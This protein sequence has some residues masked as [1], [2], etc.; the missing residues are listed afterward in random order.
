MNRKINLLL[1]CLLVVGALAAQK[2]EVLSMDNGWRFHKG[3][4]PFPTIKGHSASYSNAKAGKSW[5]AAAPN[6]D[7]SDWRVLNLP[8]DWAVE[9]GFNPEANLSQGYRDRGY[10]WYRRKFEVSSADKGKHFEL[11]LDGIATYATIW[12]NGTLLHRNWCGYTSSYIDVTPYITYDGEVNTISVRVDANSQEGWWYEG[13]GIY[14]HVWFVKRAPLH[15]K[16]D[17]V[18]AHPVR[19]QGTE[20]SLPVE[21]TLANIGKDTQEAEI[22]VTLFNPEMQQVVTAKSQ[23]SVNAL[24]EAVA[25]MDMKVLNPELWD[26]E[27]PTLY[28]V[29][30]VVTCN[31]TETDQLTTRCGFRTTRFDANTGFYL[32]DKPLK[33]KG[34]CN[35]QDHAGVGVAVPDALWEFRL[36][37]LKEMGVNGYRCAHNP[38]SKEFLDACD[39]IGILVMDENRVFNTSPEYVGQMQWLVKRDRNHPSV[40]LWSVFNEEPMQGTENGYEM[41]RRMSDVVKQLDSSRPVTA[42]MNGGLSA[43]IN[44]S[45]AVDVVGFNY[46]HWAYDQFRKDNPE[47]KLTSSEDV[48]AF[49]VR[50]E[51]KTDLANNIMDSYDTECADWGLT[52]RRGWKEVAE[53]PWLAGCFV[54]TG[55]DYRGEPTPFRWPSAGSFFGIMDLCGFPKMAYYL[56]QA[57]WVLDK[58]LLNIVPHW[59]WPADS[60]GKKIKVMTLTNADSV[61]L[62]LNGKMIGAEKVDKYEMNTFYVPYTPGRL[63]AIAYKNGKPYAKQKVETTGVPVKLRL[64]PD[65][66]ALNNDGQDAMPVTIELLDAKGR[67]VPTANHPLTFS[68]KGAAQII[69]LGNGNPNSHEAEKGNKRNLF[70]GYAQVIV[71]SLAGETGTVV[72]T[73]ET[74]GIPMG[75]VEIALSSATQIDAIKEL[76]PFISLDRWKVSPRSANRPDPNVKLSDN[77][78]NSWESINP[79]ALH[80]SATSEYVTFRT[81]FAP[82]ASHRTAG[83]ILLLKGVK[84]KAEIWL[85]GKKI[86]TKE[87][88]ESEDMRI[89]FEPIEGEQTLN[90][91]LTGSDSVG[92]GGPA[93]VLLRQ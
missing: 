70:N 83:G 85:N 16:T 27:N 68:L 54:W 59:N 81:Q 64:T 22:S 53:R 23:V 38:P 20:W 9:Q 51:Y 34:V 17:G 66:T 41:V 1:L 12:V 84:G 87:S 52:H 13:A 46:Q 77:D 57:Q 49:Q 3:D 65:R 2:R 11:Q 25:R 32:N 39:S 90:I 15:I 60:I 50:G 28:T 74:A 6:Y 29:K 44:V 75:S 80:P 37:K 19:N 86:A 43:P 8:H 73:A 71:Q 78:M 89:P 88:T 18:F 7:D 92:L 56:H 55:F 76:D 63:E 62:L 5:G 36:R 4:I 48:S 30:T 79:G 35:H 61:K 58:P 42:A 26:V 31:G 24:R 33:I 91:L 14:R 67:H 10:G 40:I 69:G 47:M 21:V 45:Q 82:F 72:L 93:S